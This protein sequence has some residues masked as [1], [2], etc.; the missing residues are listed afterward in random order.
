MP[1]RSG[2]LERRI[3]LAVGV[4]I[5]NVREP[6]AAERTVTEN[7]CSRGLRVIARRQM[8]PDE[9]LLVISTAGTVKAQ[10]RVVY[11]QPL[12]EGSFGIGLYFEGTEV[13]WPETF[14]GTSA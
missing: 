6:N 13:R 1:S 9:R 12:P 4:R 3:R 5:S 7:V 11:C 14:P 10:A 2:R 8:V